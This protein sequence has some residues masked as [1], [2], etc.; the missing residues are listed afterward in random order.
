MSKI[1][2]F[3]F[4][5]LGCFCFN[6]QAESTIQVDNARARAT[7][8]F[9]KTGAVYLTLVNNSEV[10]HSLLSVSVSDSVAEEAQIHTT[11][12][13]GDMMQM[14]E[15]SSG[16]S[17][18]KKDKAIF[19]PGGMHIM[20]LGLKKPLQAGNSLALTLYFADGQTLN[21]VVPIVDMTL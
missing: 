6:L 11:V 3:S 20:L 7:F 21:V 5:F 19:Q 18:A 10:A 16:V 4:I 13:S 17:I 8:L 15:M 14:R 9:A 2:W 12:M 1:K